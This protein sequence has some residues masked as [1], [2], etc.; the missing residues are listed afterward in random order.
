MLL[1]VCD[2]FSELL[3]A[4]PEFIDLFV[5]IGRLG[6]S[7]GVHLLLASQ[8]LEEGRLRGLDTHLSYRIGLRTFSAIESRAV[9]GVPDAYE[10]PRSPGHGY[11]KFGTEPLVRFKAA[12]VSG[13]Y[14]PPVQTVAPDPSARA[15]A[16]GWAIVPFT[17]MSTSHVA[18]VIPTPVPA[19]DGRGLPSLLDVLTAAMHGSGTAAH[20]VWLPPLSTSEPLDAVLGP[21]ALDVTRGLSVVD[22]SLRGALR[23]PVGVVDRPFEQRRDPLWLTWTAA[24]GTSRSSAA[25]SP[26]SPSCVRTLICALA[27]THTPREVHVLLPRLRRRRARRR[28][29]T[30][31]TSVASPAG[32]TPDAVRRTVGEVATLLAAR[33]RRF[34]ATGVDSIARRSRQPTA[35][36]PLRRRVPGRRRLVDGAHRL[37]RPGAGDHRH[38]HARPVLRRPR[39]DRGRPAGRTSGRRSATCSVSRLELRLGDPGDSHGLPEGG[40]RRAEACPGS[41]PDRPTAGTSSPLSPRA[42]PAARRLTTW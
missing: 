10:L 25:R 3:S 21:I 16:T 35:L 38:R 13:P 26:A 14:R 8:R 29:A 27:L 39:G 33:E 36:D 37:R 6:R 28:C 30:C 20:R 22:A 24:P 17:A 12:Y 7:L 4:K 23:V 19:P 11:L 5:A 40:D 34:A 32:S 42:R 1:V 9:L 15:T 2:E 18:A 31:R 41:W